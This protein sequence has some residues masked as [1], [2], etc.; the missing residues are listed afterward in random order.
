[1]YIHICIYIYIYICIHLLFAC[2]MLYLLFVIWRGAAPPTPPSRAPGPGPAS[3]TAAPR[4]A[5]HII[6]YHMAYYD[7]T[8]YNMIWHDILMSHK[9]IHL[10]VYIYIYMY[11]YIY[12]YILICIYIYIHTCTLHL[13]QHLLL[14]GLLQ[15]LRGLVVLLLELADAVLERG[16]RVLLTEILLPRFAWLASNCST[17]NCLSS[18]NKRT[19]ANNSNW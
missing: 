11:I 7:I 5:C 14:E 18:F 15:V 19:S 10:C 13:D 9:T 16:G 6:S 2:C 8:W 1:M 17:G 4:S 12:I 3:G